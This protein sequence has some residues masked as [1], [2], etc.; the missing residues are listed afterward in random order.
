MAGLEIAQDV[1]K[2]WI[3]QR[4][5]QFV[6]K[7]VNLEALDKIADAFGPDAEITKEKNQNGLEM[8]IIVPVAGN[9]LYL[10]NSV[11]RTTGLEHQFE[12]YQI[13]FMHL[14][15]LGKDSE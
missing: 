15:F 9:S 10:A 4:R 3:T 13:S 6:F 1:F 11:L 5:T 12:A 7:S 8:N 2:T 14:V